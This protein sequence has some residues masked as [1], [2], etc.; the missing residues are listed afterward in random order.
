MNKVL[1]KVIITINNNTVII[2]ITIHI[3]IF[4]YT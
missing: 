2:I 3:T 1:T 4:I